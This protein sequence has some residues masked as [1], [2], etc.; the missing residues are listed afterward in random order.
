MTFIMEKLDLRVQKTY[1]SLIDAF[2]KL[3]VKNNLKKY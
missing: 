1:R 3:L 2:E